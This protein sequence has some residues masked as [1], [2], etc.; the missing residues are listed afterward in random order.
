MSAQR[1]GWVTLAGGD[2]ISASNGAESIALALE[3]NEPDAIHYTSA[4]ASVAGSTNVAIVLDRLGGQ[5]GHVRAGS[6]STIVAAPFTITSAVPAQLKMGDAVTIEI[7]PSP[8][9][10]VKGDGDSWQLSASGACIEDFLSTDIGFGT[11]PAMTSVGAP[12]AQGHFIFKT[13]ALTLIAS[14]DGNQD[15]N[16]GC[17]LTIFVRHVHYGRLDPALGPN[18]GD[19]SLLV[20]DVPGDASLYGVEGLQA[21]AIHT[22]LAP[23]Q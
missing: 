15:T 23:Q 1:G 13:T 18:V 17:E 6:S 11:E 22:V 21:R 7:D 8:A 5:T 10:D 14:T 16:E 2:T 19:L 4:F 20:A 3:P 9:P 12:D